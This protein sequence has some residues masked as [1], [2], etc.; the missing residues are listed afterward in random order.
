[1]TKIL[2][3]GGAGFIGSSLAEKLVANPENYVVAVDNLSTGHVENLPQ[4]RANFRFIK[5]NVNEYGDISAVM[6]GFQF[7]YVFHYAAC[8]GVQR[9]LRNP[10]QVLCDIDGIKNVLGLAKNT[11]V[12]RVF[13]SSSSEVYGEPVEFPQNEET[14]PLNSK[15]PYAVVKNVGE[16]FLRSYKREYGLDFTIFR[17]FN[18]YGPKQS[19]DFVMTKFIE[20]ALDG[21]D[22]TVYGDG[23]QS[24]TFCY[25][26]DNV[27]AT[28]NALAQDK[29]VNEVV[30]IGNEVEVSVLELAKQVVAATESRSR[31]VHVAPLPE[32]DM[33]RRKPDITKMR[34]LLGRELTPLAE[35]ISKT[36]APRAPAW[37]EF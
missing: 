20:S 25:I 35:G 7:D 28:V 26:G 1:M 22:I 4:P 27:D 13:Y 3:T 32:G 37:Q 31:I 11:G 6:L 16:S 9:T 10:V 30:N 33:S 5:T 18:T 23:T 36:I 17:F 14:T 15:L 21:R 29:C 12:R 2:I 24:R 34:E 19:A 8:V